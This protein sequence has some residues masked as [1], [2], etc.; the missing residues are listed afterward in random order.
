MT[1]E[2]LFKKFSYLIR[3]DE[4]SN[5]RYV[6][7]SDIDALNIDVQTKGLLR[8]LFKMENIKLIDKKITSKERPKKVKDYNYGEVQAYG[9]EHLDESA[10]ATIEYDGEEL[11]FE[12]YDELDKF[13]LDEFVPNNV[14]MKV[15]RSRN[16]KDASLRK[17]YPSIQLGKIIKLGLSEKEV[18][19]VINLLKENEIHVGGKD[20][21]LDED[22]ENYDYITT[23]NIVTR[24]ADRINKTPLSWEEMQ[25]KFLE[26]YDTKDPILREELIARHLKLVPYCTW[27]IALYHDVD[28]DELNSYGYEGLI[29][30]VDNYDPYRDGK[31]ST[32]AV[33]CITG[34]AKRGIA[35]IKNI[36]SNLYYTFNTLKKMVE[37]EHG[38]KLE[39]NPKLIDIILDAMV[40]QAKISPSSKDAYRRL[41]AP[42]ISFEEVK[43]TKDIKAHVDEPYE[44]VVEAR[45]SLNRALLGLTAREKEVL[46]L[47]YGLDN[48]RRESLEEVGQKL[49][50]T[51]ERVRQIE[52]KAIRKIRNPMR[53]RQSNLKSYKDYSFEERDIKN[54]SGMIDVVSKDEENDEKEDGFVR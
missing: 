22:R 29:Y 54:I 16:N 37:E 41:L 34:F 33:P 35:E 45:Q 9:V 51:R 50:I 26:Y 27:K 3:E 48:N 46:V 8:L 21:G 42:T 20:T 4:N 47:R 53:L 13:I 39:E 24:Y 52:A 17:P 6:L 1:F 15:N 5:R 7:N 38:C 19:H 49:G 25:E 12:N 32:Y 43:E 14:Q 30:S 11:V 40:A 36:P 31:F 2:D 10:I 18:N 44:S 23:Y 28:V